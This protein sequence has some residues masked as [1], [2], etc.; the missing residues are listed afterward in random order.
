MKL[1]SLKF[2]QYPENLGY[3]NYSDFPPR[4]FKKAHNPPK[5]HITIP[6]PK[7]F[8]INSYSHAPPILH[9]KLIMGDEIAKSETLTSEEIKAASVD[10]TI[11][12]SAVGGTE[13]TCNTTKHP[14]G[15]CSDPENLSSLKYADE[16][17]EKGSVAAKDH[18][19]AEASDCYSRALEIRFLFFLYFLE[20][21]F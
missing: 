2:K 1:Y 3:N 13:S 4:W 20:L 10:A 19:Y 6:N 17:M 11:E 14:T 12:S 7:G 21:G 5:P 16:L 9:T 8:I 18:D 15:E